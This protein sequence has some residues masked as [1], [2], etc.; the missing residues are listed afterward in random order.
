MINSMRFVLSF[1]L[2]VSGISLLCAG[3]SKNLMM[4]C[5]AAASLLCAATAYS[6]NDS[7][8][9]DF[10]DQNEH[11]AWVLNVGKDGE[12]CANKWYIGQPGSN[13]GVNGLYISGDGGVTTNYSGTPTFVAAY[14]ILTLPAGTYELSFDWQA[15]GA[16]NDALYVTWIAANEETN[17]V[18]SGY[19]PK[20]LTDNP[21]T[22]GDS[23][24]LH[25][26]PWHTAYGTI[27]SDGTP[28]KLIFSWLNEQR[29]HSPAASIDN[30]N[31]I[32]VGMCEQPTHLT[33]EIT[34]SASVCIKWKSDAEVYDVRLLT[35]DGEWRIYEGITNNMLTV[36]DIPEG[37]VSVYVRAGC[38]DGYNSAWVSGSIFMFHKGTRCIDYLDL[39]S[40]RC[41]AGT[42]SN[43][44][45][46]RYMADD[47]YRSIN[48]RHTVHWDITEADPR[49]GM[50]LRTVP[51]GELASVRLG[52]WDVNKGA[53]AIEYDYH[54]DAEESAVLLMQYAVVLQNPK[55]DS[56][57]QPR[58][59]LKVLHEDGSMIDEYGCGEADF[60]AGVNTE[61]WD[62]IGTGSNVV[63]W[64]DWTTVGI[65][66]KDY[67]GQDLV[68][69]LTTY[70]CNEGAHFG[71]A[72]FVLGCSDGRILGLSCG[73]SE[74]NSFKAPDG[75]LYRW[76]KE[77]APEITIDSS[78]VFSTHRTDTAMYCCDVI[79]PTNGNC[80]YTVYANATP[81]YPVAEMRY[82]VADN[83]CQN[84]VAFAD[85]S[86]I[87]HVNPF[88]GDTTYSDEKCDSIV[89]DF[90]DGSPLSREHNP[91]HVFPDEGGSFSVT[92]KA[93]LS[94][95]ENVGTMTLTLPKG[96]TVR[97][98]VYRTACNGESVYFAGAE[99]TETGCYSDTTFNF[100]GEGCDSISVLCL[101]A[102]SVSDTTVTDT[103]CSDELP[104]GFLGEKYYTTGVYRHRLTSVDMCD[105]VVILDL[106]VN[107][108][109]ELTSADG[110]TV[111]ADDVEV[112]IPVNMEKGDVD[113]VRMEIYVDDSVVTLSG[114]MAEDV[115]VVE[116]PEGIAP[117]D[118]AG[119]VVF[120][121]GLCG[122][123]VNDFTLSVYYPDSIVAQRWN[124]V[125]GVRSA[126]WNGGYEFD[127]YQWYKD[128]MPIDGETGANLY[129][130]DGLDAGAQYSV[131][132]R[133]AADGVEIM[134]C[135]VQPEMFSDI[136]VTPT[137]TFSGGS[138][139]VKSGADGTLR[140]WSVAGVLQSVHDIKDGVNTID[141]P[142][143]EG[144]YILEV[145]LKDDS[146]KVEKILVYRR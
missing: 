52:N 103:V 27:V 32:P 10:E 100:K 45:S 37:G 98:T 97:D 14:R 3:A 61:G 64:K 58:F 2:P 114:V 145:Q 102:V 133:R 132:L 49:T 101:K 111:C 5:L 81:R 80:Y 76:Y 116:L 130:A 24:M 21:L 83:S 7:Y 121:N 89:W 67:A 138:I 17:S 18:A 84:I 115:A 120:G 118:Y 135:P 86:Y 28:H 87:M 41:Y 129:V 44:Y 146:R 92:M 110:A 15:L 136:E 19:K 95:C 22:I 65:N 59:T 107:D 113:T 82:E 16:G 73:E 90:G 40:A 20:W 6:Q 134:T 56:A 42:Y 69:R 78:Q 105:S 131:L 126:A 60:F 11:H 91:T 39:K 48:S 85:S 108:A 8:Y 140:V 46:S 38:F 104:Y 4:F 55:H 47:G 122:D 127:R 23:L 141:V 62:S 71:Y 124:D 77:S 31:I 9:C 74:S 36:N 68:I 123:V 12:N 13:G 53:E 30:I 128:G 33:L 142:A 137:V 50:A 35:S 66:L 112:A 93:Y 25:Y 94:D 43:P 125:L 139:E 29:T 1:H 144:T 143:V 119:K 51:D 26:E 79:Q 96:G 75:F 72:Y 99:R 106:T 34:D 70:D 88:T 54:V 117:G 63:L 109:L 57:D